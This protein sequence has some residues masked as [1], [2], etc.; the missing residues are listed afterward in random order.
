MKGYTYTIKAQ[1]DR[2]PA[3][4]YERSR[5]EPAQAKMLVLILVRAFRSVE[6]INDFTGE[7]ECQRYASAKF[8]LPTTT[9]YDTIKEAEAVIAHDDLHDSED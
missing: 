2:Q 7:V 5:L 9:V 8:F 4:T 6:V 3:I 1:T